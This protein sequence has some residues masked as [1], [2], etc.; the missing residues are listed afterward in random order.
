MGFRNARLRAGL[1]VSEVMSALGVSDAAVYQ[2][3]TGIFK[4]RAA[5]LLRISELY[6]CTMEELLTPD[7]VSDKESDK[8]DSKEAHEAK[9]KR[10]P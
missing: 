1:R 9:R 6:G 7:I 5:M 10:L 3:E 4:P 2:W 8:T